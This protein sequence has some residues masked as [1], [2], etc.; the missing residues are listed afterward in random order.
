MTMGRALLEKGIIGVA[1][2][3][4][5]MWYEGAYWVYHGGVVVVL[6]NDFG[7]DG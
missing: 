3:K 1:A 7:E 2:M 6:F 5:K 4:G